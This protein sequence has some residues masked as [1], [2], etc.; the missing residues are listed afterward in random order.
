MEQHPIP[1]QISSYE[2]K[3]VGE[4]TLKQFLKAA[5][6]IILAILI[7]STKLLVLVKW[8]L[9]L[10]SAGVGLLLAFV[11]FEDRP[12][13]TWIT[14]FIKSIYSPTIYTYK[15]RNENNWLDLDLTK[16]DKQSND[17]ADSPVKNEN[18][19][20]VDKDTKNGSES[21]LLKEKNRFTHDVAL[22]RQK[23]SED[24]IKEVEE[25]NERKGKL[26][27]GNN[28]DGLIKN[29]VIEIKKEKDI[30]TDSVSDWR[31][32]K[33]DLNLK[34]EKLEATGEAVFGT[35]PMPDRPDI[36]NMVVGMATSS[37]GK[38]VDGVII[39]IQDEHGVP[40]R[41]I[42]TNS[43]GQFK[44]STPLANGRYLIIAEKEG[45]IFDRVNIDLTGKII[46]PIR[47]IAHK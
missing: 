21:F 14:A 41:V 30:E 16:T 29:D 17:D 5:A 9:M 15:K 36:A 19:F 25:E 18:L 20:V 47:I 33:I 28:I 12:L 23:L 43:L 3:L 1:Q 26:L 24:L 32:K 22:A 37:E 42:K 40:T 2:F 7:N 27:I 45:Y 11:P 10:I 13:E 34:R 46:D 38:I 6:G 39:E 8:P 31:D 35:I 44:I 4:M